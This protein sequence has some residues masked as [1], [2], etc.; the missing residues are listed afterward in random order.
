M[1][2]CLNSRCVCLSVAVLM[3]NCLLSSSQVSSPSPSVKQK[4][5]I[6]ILRSLSRGVYYLIHIHI[7]ML[8]SED[9]DEGDSFEPL[10]RKYKI[11]VTV[12]LLLLVLAFLGIGVFLILT[13]EG[14]K[15][16]CRELTCVPPI[17]VVEVSEADY[18]GCLGVKIGSPGLAAKLMVKI[19]GFEELL[20]DN[21]QCITN[22]SNGTSNLH[23]PY[24]GERCVSATSAAWPLL[25]LSEL[26]SPSAAM[27]QLQQLSLKSMER[28]WNN[29]FPSSFTCWKCQSSNYGLSNTCSSEITV[30]VTPSEQSLPALICGILLCAVAA[31]FSVFWVLR[32]GFTKTLA[33]KLHSAVL[34]FLVPQDDQTRRMSNYASSAGPKEMLPKLQKEDVKKEKMT[35]G[36][37]PPAQSRGSVLD[38]HLNIQ[39]QVVAPAKSVLKSPSN[40]ELQPQQQP[41]ANG[42]TL[43][44]WQARRSQ[45]SERSLKDISIASGSFATRS[46]TLSA[47]DSGSSSERAS[48]ERRA[49]EAVGRLS[50]RLTHS[51]NQSSLSS[52]SSGGRKKRRRQRSQATTEPHAIDMKQPA[53][54]RSMASS[55]SSRTD[56]RP[57]PGEGG[58]RSI[59]VSPSPSSASPRKKKNSRAK[60]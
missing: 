32:K 11:I 24:P 13:S 3:H 5:S 14:L 57:S 39:V 48:S 9:E 42:K 33:R 58:A 44:N 1:G 12:T 29:A 27:H 37:A 17:R 31:S 41:G 6:N 50:S 46:A 60:K 43:M 16:G 55:V 51:T 45:V 49:V 53:P 8:P 56:T 15:D 28:S 52:G 23:K 2:I 21:I 38:N 20:W 54:R 19:D 26:S 4:K 35:K 7:Q 47:T 34:M 30:I 18:S 25:T 36:M 22:G 10:P 40:T 59:Q